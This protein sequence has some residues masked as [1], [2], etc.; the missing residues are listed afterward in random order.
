[1][2]DGSSQAGLGLWAELK[3]DVV[4]LSQPCAVQ[5]EAGDGDVDLANV[6][7]APDSQAALVSL[8]GSVDQVDYVGPRD[9]AASVGQV[10]H[11]DLADFGCWTDQV[12]PEGREQ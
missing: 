5:R 8:F 3:R 2:E 9:H 12:V 10:V 6:D 4:I 7:L 1:M 11:A